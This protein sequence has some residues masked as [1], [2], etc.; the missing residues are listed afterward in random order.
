MMGWW[1]SSA[2]SALDEQISKATS[3]SLEDIALNLDISDLIRSKTVPPKEAMRSLKKRIGDK[4][5]NTQLSALNLTDTCVKNG[6]QH[7]LVEIASR[8]FMD[9]LTSL[10]KAVGPAAVNHDVRSKIL[11]CIQSWAAATEGRYELNYIGEVYKTLQREGFQFP[12]RV[13]V[14]SSMIDSS[15]PPEWVDS[16]V[17][18]RCRTA[19]TFT[20]RKHHCRNCGNVFDQ[21]CSTKTI[22]LPHLG[23]MQPVRVDD[24]CYA[25]LT[26]RSG[27]GGSFSQSERPPKISSSVKRHSSSMQPRNA[28][29]DDGFDEDLKKALAMSL[30]EVQSHSRGYVAPKVN[31]PSSSAKTNGHST[32]KAAEEEDD[33]LKA[34]IAA[35][36]ADMEEQKKKHA[37]ALKEST[38]NV[39]QASSSTFALPKNDY[40]LT[41]VEAENI[42]LF[43]TLVDRLQ[44]QAP[45]TILREPQIQ[46]LYD[47]IGTLRPK[48]ARTYGETMSKHDTLLDLHAK[49][50][51]AVRYYD[52]M[53]EERLSKAFN[54]HSLGGYNMPAPRQSSGPYPTLHT[55]APTNINGPAESFYT[56]EAQQDYSRAAAPSAYPHQPQPTAQPQYPGYD[57]P[58]S[59]SG[60]PHQYPP[61]QRQDSWRASAPPGQAPQY[62]AQQN[63]PPSEAAT[64][65]MSHLAL[66]EQQPNAPE[67]VGTTPTSDPNASFYL[68]QPGQNTPQATPSAPSEFAPSP[69]PNL[70][71]Q[72]PQYSQQW[73]PETPGSAPPQAAQQPQQS[74]APPQAQAPYWQHPAAQHVQVPA[75]SA[76]PWQQPAPQQYQQA[77]PGYQQETFPSAPQHALPQPVVEEALIEL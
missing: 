18:M 26:D 47:S 64:P 12:P 38:S 37:A 59:M 24:G 21:Q 30:E 65:Q 50:Q 22:P 8:E 44:T 60:A 6:G 33:D 11:E 4:N 14:S 28:R 76:A 63:H 9:N 70:Q 54:Q 73:T 43:S 32:S 51:T 35:S 58:A 5:P 42:N 15:A 61:P 57:R 7:F 17:C 48:L 75:P 67:S 74:S 55:S 20:N 39:D 3:S 23:I 41:P 46:E 66:P 16:D 13:T 40:E 49:L 31:E 56:G 34:A 36:L 72:M 1:S 71:Q 62:A 10:L 53:L 77:Y 25:K 45:G 19:F 69:Y 68:N 29:V 27:R 2:G 52:R